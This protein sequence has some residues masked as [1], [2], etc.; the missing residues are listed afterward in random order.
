MTPLLRENRCIHCGKLLLR[1]L[2]FSGTIEIRCTRCKADNVITGITSSLE[3][4]DQYSIL[5]DYQ[6][7]IMG[8]D[9]NAVAILGY[10]NE[11][12]QGMHRTALGSDITEKDYAQLRGAIMRGIGPV[13]FDT[14][15]RKK[16]GTAIPVNLQVKVFMDSE[17][18]VAL[19]V[20]HLISQQKKSE[21]R[22]EMTVN[23]KGQF[24]YLSK[25]AANCLG[26]RWVEFIGTPMHELF[27]GEEPNGEAFTRML[28]NK[29]FFRLPGM[30]MCRKDGTFTKCDLEF[31]PQQN[32][33]GDFIGYA[34]V[35]TK[36]R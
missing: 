4:T 7:N 23:E 22:Y 32:D 13:S 1:G 16:D 25:E 30:A 31:T 10:T 15:H 19:V 34:V 8:A 28:E 6:G 24:L 27:I 5:F 35:G 2:V 14:V 21:G 9:R 26:D 3:R 29:S 17:K 20:G 33:L 18:P 36:R 11:E 12:L